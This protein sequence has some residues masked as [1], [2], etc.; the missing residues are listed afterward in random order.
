MIVSRFHSGLRAASFVEFGQAASPPDGRK[1][2][3][4]RA[5]AKELQLPWSGEPR[6]WMGARPTLPDYLPAIGRSRRADNLL[7]AFGHQHLGL[8]LAAI[9]GD[10]V[11]SLAAG[12]EPSIDL[13]PFDLERFG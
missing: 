2:Q 8:T 4:L 6:E 9:T 13:R 10:L 1:W 12:H 5:H 3:R 11:G 7:Y